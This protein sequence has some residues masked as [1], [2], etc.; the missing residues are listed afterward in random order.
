M[1]I[2][3][4]LSVLLHSVDEILIEKSKKIFFYTTRF[5]SF[6]VYTV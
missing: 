6:F 3:K 5:I 1:L 4:L 2:I